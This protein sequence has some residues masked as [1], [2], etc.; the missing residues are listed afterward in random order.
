MLDCF[1]HGG[2]STE[3]TNIR[4]WVE[5]EPLGRVLLSRAA[6]FSI[7]FSCPPPCTPCLKMC[8][9]N[10]PL[11]PASHQD[12]GPPGVG[13][14]NMSRRVVFICFRLFPDQ[15][16]CRGREVRWPL[17]DLDLARLLP[18]LRRK[19]VYKYLPGCQGQFLAASHWTGWVPVNVH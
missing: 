12:F 10:G 2:E 1:R 15:R 13:T 16:S 7:P 4:G 3:C 6:F 8:P 17:I 19:A 11:E 18:L 5:Q 9:V 14:R